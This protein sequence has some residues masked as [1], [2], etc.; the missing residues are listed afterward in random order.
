VNVTRLGGAL[1][2]ATAIG[3][4]ASGPAPGGRP[5]LGSADA[6]PTEDGSAPEDPH[7]ARAHDVAL[8][9]LRDA[10]L[11]ALIAADP[12]TAH[13]IDRGPLRP[14]PAS[15]GARSPLRELLS[16]AQRESKGIQ[17]RRLAAQ[18]GMLLRAI[19]FGLDALDRDLRAM[20]PLRTDPTAYVRRAEGFVTAVCRDLAAGSAEGADGALEALAVE[21]REVGGLLGGASLPS[22]RAGVVDARRLATA[23]RRTPDCAATP[24]ET[25]R[26]AADDAA[27]AAEAL[28]VHLEAVVA[29]LPDADPASWDDR[30]TPQT[31][32]AGVRRLPEVWG[33]ARL[34][35]VLAS[36]ELLAT[37]ASTLLA[38]SVAMVGR[39]HTMRDAVA[40]A[41]DTPREPVTLA[42]CETAWATISGWVGSQPALAAARLDCASALRKLAT[43]ELDDADLDVA[44]VDL[45]VVT[46]TRLARRKEVE[47]ALAFATGA[48][49]PAA[50][51]QALAIS[52]LRGS[53]RAAAAYRATDE[54]LDAACLAATALVVHGE[55]APADQLASRIGSGCDHRTAA[56]WT[57]DAVARPRAALAGLGL[58]QLGAG[59]AD[60]VAL[61]AFWWAPMGLVP[62]LAR[63]PEPETEAPEGT[64]PGVKVE[65]L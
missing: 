51:R 65:P 33:A 29:A 62:M 9:R 24:N 49:T 23:V 10:A 16:A 27:D 50:Q 41:R 61:H 42:R 21:L 5:D 1:L 39:L 36:E 14:P 15:R 35:S 37:D 12:I 4:P 54:A 6:G 60:A 11:P 46:P 38:E 45:G 34:R 20:T 31:D 59:P 52:V 56:Q 44:L 57:E 53:G 8:G 18:P 7:L 40:K 58:L 30:L 64:N 47:P 48:A 32:A 43:P 2:C 28:A 26:K 25:L 17:A 13:E 22:A 19:Q 3:C 63:P 55:L